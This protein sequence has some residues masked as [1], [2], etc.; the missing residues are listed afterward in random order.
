MT[1]NDSAHLMDALQQRG[2]G[3]VTASWLAKNLETVELIDVREPHELTGPLGCIPQAKNVPLLQWVGNPGRLDSD[4]AVVLICRSGRRSSM[5]AEALRGAGHRAV[6]SV[7]GGMLAWNIDV[8]GKEG[9]H[10]QEKIANTHNL[11]EAVF[12]TNGLPEVSAGWVQNNLGRFRLIDVRGAAELEEFGRVAQA[13]HIEMQQF[14]N[15]AMD[16]DHEAPLVVMCASGG[17]SGRVVSALET[18]GFSAVASLEGGLFG[19]RSQDLPTV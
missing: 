2:D 10:E 4:A 11:S 15:G 14:V 5:A 6:A 19:W 9:V 12:R 16:L 17:R 3:E 7:E 8:L 18:M 13:E 1:T